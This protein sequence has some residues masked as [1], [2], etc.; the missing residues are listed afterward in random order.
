MDLAR[1][2][3][4]LGLRKQAEDAVRAAVSLN[5]DNRFILRSAARFYVHIKDLDHAQRL[6][7]S[8]AATRTDPWL[9]AAEI[10]VSEAR[11]RSSKLAGLGRR[12]LDNSELAAAD[13]SE[14]ASAVATMELKN[15]NSRRARQFFRRSLERPTENSVA[16][17]EWATI[18]Q[19]AGLDLNVQSFDA[20]RLYE[21]RAAEAFEAGNW[22]ISLTES[23][24]WFRDQAFSSRPVMLASYLSS[25]LIPD[26]NTARD[27]LQAGLRANP[28]D[29][30]L[31]NNLAFVQAT[32]GDLADAEDTLRRAERYGDQLHRQ[33]VLAATNGLLLFRRHRFDEGR[34]SYLGA[35]TEAKRRLEPRLEA[36]ARVFLALEETR[37]GLP[38]AASTAAE[39]ISVAE[40]SRYLDVRA[41]AARLAKAPVRSVE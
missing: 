28:R 8:Q 25:V 17:A 22:N 33:I 10:A 19:G 35:I 2:Y 11:G 37:A 26:P 30:G 20:P 31:L 7:S 41:L 15:G 9:L 27:V 32:S 40:G 6:L 24:R 3:A 1:E 34:A 5:P 21:A 13:V 14:L 18:E 4:I 23:L 39:A 12:T 36:L 29:V 16:Q 38:T